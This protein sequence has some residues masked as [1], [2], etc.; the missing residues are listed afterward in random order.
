MISGSGPG[1]CAGIDLRLYRDAG[2][3]AY[4]LRSFLRTKWR[5]PIIAAV[6]GFAIGAGFELALAAD[7]MVAAESAVLKLPEVGVGLIAAGGGLTRLADGFPRGD[8]MRLILTTDSLSGRR[9]YERGLAVE[10]VADGS[11]APTALSIA[12]HIGRQDLTRWSPRSVCSWTR[13]D[14]Q[15][16]S[17]GAF[18]TST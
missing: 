14:A 4:G 1:F 13:L 17:D 3:V 2:R 12:D 6:E 10:C 16:P 8:A 5:K 9:A 11:A 15:T 7:L 18:R